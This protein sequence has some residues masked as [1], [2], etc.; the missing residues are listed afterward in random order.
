MCLA[1]KEREIILKEETKARDVKINEAKKGNNFFSGVLVLSLSAVI[2]K[3]IGLVYKIPMLRLLGSEGMGYFNSAY[4]IYALFCVISTAGLPVAMSVMISRSGERGMARKIF[5]VSMSLFLV[6]GI[7]GTLVMLLCANPLAMLLKSSKAMYSIM[8][9]APTVL[10]ICISSAYRGYFQGLGTMIPTAVSQIIEALG[11]LFI[12]LLFAHIAFSAG[13]DTEMIAAFAVI[14]LT[15]GTAVSAL[16]LALSK[17]INNRRETPTVK[18]R[19]DGRIAAELMKTAIPVTLSSA[20]ISLTKVIDM[21]MI[22]RRMQTVGFSENQAFS[23][24]GNYTTLAVPLFSVAPALI[25]SVALPLVPALSSA[26]AARDPV[27][28]IRATSDAI[29]LALIVSMPIS[30]GLCMFSEPILTLI[31]PRE[32]EAVSMSAPLLSVLGL[33]VTMSCLVTVSNS[34]LQ[35]YGRPT[36]P[37]WSM[38]TGTAIKIIL[39]YFLIGNREVNIMGAPISTLFCD[40]TIVIINLHYVNKY[41]PA[42]LSAKDLMWR[43]FGASLGAVFGARVL[44]YALE[45]RIGESP[46]LTILSVG[47]AAVIYLPMCALT[48]AISREDIKKFIG[49]SMEKNTSRVCE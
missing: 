8:A 23:A 37:I 40:F 16:Y 9:I 34:V 26:I 6:L 31:F 24:Y 14:G 48:R 42:P 28:Q 10:F 41:L 30:I 44:Y 11:K 12:G 3:I 1:V 38:A 18:S 4:E 25:S 21:T 27:G 49:P 29:K 36:V 45:S 2:V 39:A 5:K 7:I 33:S 17:K 22:L 35:A 20:V 19:T 43:P 13:F 32:P 15:L 47:V 46:L